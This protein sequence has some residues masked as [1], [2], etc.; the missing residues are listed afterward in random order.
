MTGCPSSTA[1]SRRTSCR[2]RSCSPARS[3][4]ERMKQARSGKARYARSLAGQLVKRL[5]A[6]RRQPPGRALRRGRQGSRGIDE[7]DRRPRLRTAPI[8]LAPRPEA[9]RIGPQHGG[10]GKGIRRS[11]GQTQVREKA[12]EFWR[13]KLKGRTFRNHGTGLEI[14]VSHGGMDE[15][16]SHSGDIRRAQLVA[17]LPEIIKTAAYIED[18]RPHTPAESTYPHWFYFHAEAVLTA[19]LWN[20]CSTWAV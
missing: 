18:K 20:S 11:G 8:T 1:R 17:R 6:D 12:R 15:I 9:G 4:Q 13:Q 19:N 5:P 3:C 7:G 10:A 14:G 16:L 2:R